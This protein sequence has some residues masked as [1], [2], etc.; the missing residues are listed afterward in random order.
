MVSPWVRSLS[1]IRSL[2]LILWLM[3]LKHRLLIIYL[4]NLQSITCMTR[5]SLTV[6]SIQYCFLSIQIRYTCSDRGQQ[7]CGKRPAHIYSL[8]LEKQ[9]IILKSS[10]IL[11][12]NAEIDSIIAYNYMSLFFFLFKRWK[13]MV[14]LPM[15]F[16]FFF[17]KNI[18]TYCIIYSN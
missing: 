2:R 13:L 4:H 3:S 16:L 10:T 8:S 5:C 12:T 9:L 17:Y 14:F 6:V 15:F 11:M 1:P 7:S 18:T